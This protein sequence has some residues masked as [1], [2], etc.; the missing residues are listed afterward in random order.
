MRICFLSAGNFAHVGPYLDYFK[1]AGHDVR[2]LALSPSPPRSVPVY[3]LS[4]GGGYDAEGGKWKYPL[5]MLRARALIR[6]LKPDIV[7]AHYA[8]SGGLASLVCGHHPTVVTAH[9][10]DLAAGVES[11][12]WR[13][14]LKATFD[15]A[16]C[17]NAV[18]EELKTLAVGLGIAPA[19]IEVLTLGVDTQRFSLEPR[20]PQPGRPLRL[21]CTR[22]LEPVYDPATI[23]E[24]LALVRAAGLPFSMTFAGEGGLRAGIQALASRLGLGAEVSFLGE[25]DH[26]ALPDLLARHDVALS[27]SRRDGTS[28]SLLESMAAGLFPIVSDIPANRAWLENGAG[29]LLHRPGDP[30]DLARL[31]L[32]LGRRP[33]L[34]APAARTNRARVMAGGDRRRNMARLERTYLELL[35]R[36]RGAAA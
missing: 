3:D 31:I 27:A 35:A 11:P 8:T 28:L 4:V 9:G 26:A 14:L 25:V 29:G 16:D 13:T 17:V 6:R 18:S 23:V 15:Q 19:K 24:A 33:G 12:V 20:A 5:S 10:T 2:F 7:H 34:I 21:I 22:R 32:E 30:R 1:E 36:A